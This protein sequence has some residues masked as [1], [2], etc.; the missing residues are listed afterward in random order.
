[1]NILYISIY[2]FLKGG[3]NGGKTLS[4]TRYL[5]VV[6]TYAKALKNVSYYQSDASVPRSTLQ[7]YTPSNVPDITLYPVYDLGSPRQC[8]VLF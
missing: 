1:M 6:E 5:F 2:I 8:I 7:W 3:G 4:F